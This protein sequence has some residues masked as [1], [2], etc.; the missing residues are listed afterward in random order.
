MFLWT[1]PPPFSVPTCWWVS[2]ILSATCP[3]R[4]QGKGGKTTA[5]AQITMGSE[6]SST[7]RRS[8]STH[9]IASCFFLTTGYPVIMRS[10]SLHRHAHTLGDH[11][12]VFLYSPGSFQSPS[13]F[14]FCNVFK[15]FFSEGPSSDP[16]FP[17]GVSMYFSRSNVSYSGDGNQM[18]LR[19]G[20]NQVRATAMTHAQASY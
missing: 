8:F 9:A 15:F 13:T 7:S 14:R 5:Y 10:C 18:G 1:F 12:E 4:R 20:K 6:L 16:S 19:S 11:H 3:F 17:W 2:L